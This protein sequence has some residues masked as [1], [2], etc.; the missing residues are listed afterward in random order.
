VIDLKRLARQRP[1]PLPT[2]FRRR[3]T[4]RSAGATG[5]FKGAVATL[6]RATDALA[7]AQE[8]PA[9]GKR[10]TLFRRQGGRN[11]AGARESPRPLGQ[12]AIVQA[13]AEM[14][15]GAGRHPRGTSFAGG[16]PRQRP[17]GY[18]KDFTAFLAPAA[19][20][21]RWTDVDRNRRSAEE[22]Y[23][24]GKRRS[25]PTP[26]SLTWTPIRAAARVSRRR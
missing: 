1:G 15:K 9:S 6:E 17:G 11:A 22:S 7:A 26:C 12:P 16:R 21:S 8:R 18:E 24:P 23:R 4:R 25:P 3:P 13:V 19:Q 14:K 20:A 5:D 10:R 2:R